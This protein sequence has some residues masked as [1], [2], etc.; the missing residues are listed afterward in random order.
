MPGAGFALSSSNARERP[1][2]ARR[3]APIDVE[4]SSD[5]R[6][7]HTGSGP[8]GRAARPSIGG[9][10][11]RTAPEAPP[12]GPTSSVRVQRPDRRGSQGT[13]RRHET[14][15]RPES[16][17]DDGGSPEHD[18]VQRRDLEQQ[19]LDE[20]LAASVAVRRFLLLVTA[21]FAI[22]GLALVCLGVFGTVS[23]RTVRRRREFAI[24]LTLGATRGRI[25]ATCALQG[26][27]PVAAGLSVGLVVSLATARARPR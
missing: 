5:S 7:W 6:V 26:L 10:D 24:R 15:D 1:L 2:T 11:S 18:G 14:G 27:R 8:Q 3:P 25:V 20:P 21:G 16:E 22:A 4:T 17:D 12:A 19:R 23:Q 13:G 9:A